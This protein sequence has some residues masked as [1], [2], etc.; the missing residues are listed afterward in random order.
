MKRLQISF[1]ES[2]IAFIFFLILF[3]LFLHLITGTINSGF[4]FMDDH[5]YISLK[6]EL[7]SSDSSFWQVLGK[8]LRMDF[9][10][11]RF[12]PIYWCL[13]VL[14]THLMKLDFFHYSLFMGVFGSLVASVLYSFGRSLQFSMLEAL[15]FVSLCLLGPQAELWWMNG[16][17]ESR[18]VFF[19]GLALLFA[20]LSARHNGH[21]GYKI[22]F[23]ITMAISAYCK[24][25]FALAIPAIML[26]KIYLQRFY[27]NTSWSLSLR[28]NFIEGVLLMCVLLSVVI[29]VKLKNP[30]MNIGYAGVSEETRITDYLGTFLTFT[31]E[32]HLALIWIV[33]IY[34]IACLLFYQLD[35]LRE[36][37][38][39]LM[40]LARRYFP[41]LMIAILFITTQVF[42]YTKSSFIGRYYIPATIPVALLLVLP[43]Y[44]VRKKLPDVSRTSRTT[45]SI[46]LA[47]AVLLYLYPKAQVAYQ[48][49][50]D[51]RVFGNEINAFLTAVVQHTPPDGAIVLVY[52]PVYDIETV[53]SFRT[54][55]NVFKSKP[56]PVVKLPT[57]Q[58]QSLHPVRTAAS[59]ILLDHRLEPDFLEE[60]RDE[61][62]PD[63]FTRQPI[64]RYIFY[65]RKP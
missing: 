40:H 51:F 61:F 31:E 47:A 1:R 38:T 12:R 59:V 24:E 9:D 41:I 33:Q 26:F 53:E 50:R 28:S 10:P 22:L 32:D 15:L 30:T 6:Q 36:L 35:S 5:T 42:I 65:Y 55:V 29:M 2:V 8:R 43:L 46:F 34:I 3:F 37:K 57:T 62:H 11:T 39:R 7:T 54:Y 64:G 56:N 45:A 49:G 27:T 58:K 17:N 23:C 19:M 60:S 48:A 4:H 21:I 13:L 25:S 63:S 44:F 18:G 20:L 16:N 14:Q 52:N